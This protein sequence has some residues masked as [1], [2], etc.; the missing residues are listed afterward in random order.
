MYVWHK[1][2]SRKT[3][4][5]VGE[6][7]KA[8]S[9]PNEIVFDPFAGSGIVGI[10]AIRHGRRAI[11]CDIN[12]AASEITE[13]TIRPVDLAKLQ[14]AFTRV[15]LK[16]K[17]KI[18]KLYEIHCVKCGSLLICDA[19][20]REA[21]KLVEVRYPKCPECGYRSEN[22]KPKR[23]DI[24]RLAE[25]EKAPISGWYPKNKLEYGDGSPFMER[26][27]FESI[28]EVFTRRNLQALSWLHESIQEE[29]SSLLRRFLMGAF[30][31]MVHL[32]SRMMPVGK[33]QATN[34]YTYF[35]SPGWTQHSYWSAFRYMEQG[36]WEK[37]R[38]AMI[39]HQGLLNAKREAQAILPSAKIT[40]DWRKVIS[41]Q[42]D[43]AIVTG[44]SL[45]LM[46]EMPRDCV[47]YIFTDPPYDKSV[48]YGELSLIWNAWTKHDDGYCDTLVAGEIIHNDRQKKNFDVYHGLLKQGFERCFS[49][50]CSGRYLTLTFHNP[51]FKVRNAT[52][53]A[54]VFA[55][56]EYQKIHH[57]PL[58][59]K[60]AKSM[61]QPFGSA[62]GDFYLRFHK[63][64]K[65][66]H[67]PIQLEE[68]TEEKFR[69]IV[70]ETCKEVIAER[71]EPTPYTILVNY[72]DPVLARHGL[73]STLNTGLDVKTVLEEAQGIDFELVPSKLGSASGKQWWFKD[74]IFA[75]RLKET[76]L[77]ERVEQTVLRVLQ[78][79]GKITFTDVWDSVSRE[80][81]NSLTSDSTSIKEALETYARQ[82]GNGFW[83]LR[84]DIRVRIQSHSEIIALLANVGRGRGFDIW[85][86][87]REQ[88][89]IAGGLAANVKL[90]SLVTKTPS[91]LVGVTNPKEVLLMDLLWLKG[92]EVIYAFEVE[93]TTTMTSGLQRGSNLPHDTPKIMVIPEERRGD[94]TRKMQ[95]PLFN[96]N[97][98]KSEWSLLYFDMLR[99][100]Y[101]KRGAL[102]TIENL[103]GKPMLKK[104][105]GRVTVASRQQRLKFSGS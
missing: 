54:G 98:K 78:S 48:Q 23:E 94:F 85:I 89:D 91:S 5:V 41:G 56:F 20:V 15:E 52:V 96:E 10:E 13:L 61:L 33:P 36:V 63:L 39:G 105:Q 31:S 24:A 12:P 64:P 29:P 17:E 58:G 102:T 6:F 21:D 55:G 50:L 1:Y 65:N 87:R 93:S 53:R 43:I 101:S 59:Q 27:R 38:S 62:Q 92:N 35:S 26:Q 9:Q 8:Y 40:N 2:W 75:R 66:A 103:L 14:E 73:F 60:S 16:I 97:F 76:P 79:Q 45:A 77:S 67:Y 44:D 7:I 47:S 69:K 4:N 28:D 104:P 51:T 34:H 88:R 95:S 22:D 42:A 49:V 46:S 99:N 100:V 30:T 32:C 86:G 84:E 57:Q 19:F 74:P 72:V 82:V 70:I 81:P 83:M 3:W 71:A 80:F 25:L 11:V 68:I 90:S 37:F 18:E